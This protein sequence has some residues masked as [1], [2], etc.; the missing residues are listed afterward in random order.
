MMSYKSLLPALLFLLA[1]PALASGSNWHSVNGS[2]S[3]RWIA[4]WQGNPVKGGFEE[5]TVKAS[6]L[7]PSG[8]AGAGLSMTLD[9]NSIKAAS[10]DITQALHGA[11]WFNINQHP[12]AR[13]TGHITQK[14]GGLE[15][16]GRLQL[17][18]HEKSLNFPLEITHQ[19]NNLVLTGHFTLQRDDFGIGTGQWSSGKTI[20]LKVEVKFSI[21]LARDHAGQA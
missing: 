13:Y 3:I 2:S 20:A 9:T 8:P 6:G 19:G 21:T 7:D 14:N 11:E 12:Q 1:A 10:P 18:G 15:A 16:E 17:K 5:F 4:N